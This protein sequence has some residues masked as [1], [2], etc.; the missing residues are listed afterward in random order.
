M[1]RE[2]KVGEK[3]LDFGDDI[4][5]SDD[6]QRYEIGKEKSVT[7]T[8]TLSRHLHPVLT[9]NH[10]MRPEE[11]ARQRLLTVAEGLVV[12]S[13]QSTEDLRGDS[14]ASNIFRVKQSSRILDPDLESLADVRLLCV[15]WMQKEAVHAVGKE[16]MG[17]SI[18]IFDKYLCLAGKKLINNSEEIRKVAAACV[19]I[20]SKIH[21][22][23]SAHNYFGIIPWVNETE[24][25]NVERMV[26]ETIQY[27]IN[28][29]NTPIILLELLILSC[30]KLQACP[31]SQKEAILQVA[32]KRVQLFQL[33]LQSMKFLP[34]VTSL[35]ALYS[36]CG[37][38][39]INP[40]WMS[41]PTLD[42]LVN[43]L[44]SS[45]EDCWR[46]F[47]LNSQRI[48]AYRGTSSSL[49]TLNDD[50]ITQIGMKNEDS[51]GDS[52]VHSRKHRGSP[53]SVSKFAYSSDI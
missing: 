20:A 15:R 39:N 7:I 11:F 40:D 41:I 28:L 9:M 37:P 36:V 50:L 52:Q 51:Y 49:D 23:R 16:G 8:T 3:H 10:S 45:I 47:L 22:R 1:E 18:D 43:A 21:S 14:E 5:W 33:S 12:P 32:E 53:D 17:T 25:E 19:V 42:A 4:G 38:M 30:P 6:C 26:L 29:H 24:L 34:L 44:K 2:C 48:F 27:E 46:E 35:S 31:V 13:P